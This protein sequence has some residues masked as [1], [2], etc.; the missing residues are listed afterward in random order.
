MGVHTITLDGDSVDLLC[1]PNAVFKLSRAY[2]G[3]TPLFQKIQSMEIEAYIAII[4]AGANLSDKE[5]GE[6]VNKVFKTGM[7]NLMTP[8]VEYLTMLCAGGVIKSE[9]KS[10]KKKS[11]ENL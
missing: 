3:I 7:M 8:L 11:P 9:E 4:R 2:S 5:S 6:L 1:T 10:D